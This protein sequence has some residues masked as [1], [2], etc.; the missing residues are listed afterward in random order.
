MYEYGRLLFKGKGLKANKEEAVIYFENAIK[1]NCLKAMHKY[2]LILMKGI[3]LPQN[4]EEGIKYIKK[5]A[6]KGYAK[7]LYS[8]SLIL[9]NDNIE[10]FK[11]AAYKGHVESTWKYGTLLRDANDI[12]SQKE[13]CRLLKK[14]CDQNHI[15]SM[16][17]YAESILVGIGIEINCEQAAKYFRIAAY[18]GNADAMDGIGIMLIY[19]N[20]IPV[21][22]EERKLSNIILLKQ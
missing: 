21:N 8:Y 14:A 16:N 7:A 12:D 3:E 2:G 10:Y 13:S 6:D 9:E 19:G 20:G 11:K 1:N 5:A 15:N 18:N 17:S 4:K 22:K